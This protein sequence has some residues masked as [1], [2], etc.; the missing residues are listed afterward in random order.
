M[1]CGT[2]LFKV[3]NIVNLFQPRHRSLL[4]SQN[5]FQL[6]KRRTNTLV[7]SYCSSYRSNNRPIFHWWI[8]QGFHSFSQ[9]I[10]LAFLKKLRFP[11]GTR[12]NALDFH[13]W[14]TI[15]KGTVWQNFQFILVF[16]YLSSLI[17]HVFHFFQCSYGD[18]FPR[19]RA[20]HYLCT[21]AC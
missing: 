10:P 1:H 9:V 14:A 17:F 15:W 20:L 2:D 5:L 4:Q 11:F 16:L 13:W 21:R 3:T 7:L 18:S 19:V 6:I 8:F 12:I